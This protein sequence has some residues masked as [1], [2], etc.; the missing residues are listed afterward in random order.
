VEYIVVDGASIDGTLDII[1][2][3]D[4]RIDYWISEPDEGVF[5]AMNKG[6]KIAKGDCIGF[7]NAGDYYE[8]QACKIISNLILKNSEIGVF[9][10]NT[11][12]IVFLRKKQYFYHIKPKQIIDK[13][14]RVE[15]LFCH[16]SS[17]VKKNLFEMFGYFENVKVAG[18]WIHFV[19]LYDNNVKFLYVNETISNYLDGGISTTAYGFKESFSYKKKFGTFKHSDYL[20]LFVFYIKDFYFYKK[21]VYPIRWGLKIFF[22]SKVRTKIDEL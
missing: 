15:P 10:G 1:R 4:D 17:F 8:L 21:Y 20:R 19:S 3:Y 11:N 9:Y 13:T 12:L 6:I 2:R 7:L 22:S 5:C 16:Q 18:E 14:I